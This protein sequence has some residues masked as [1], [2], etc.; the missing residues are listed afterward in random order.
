MWD[1]VAVL[2]ILGTMIAFVWMSVIDLKIRILPDELNLAVGVFGVLFHLAIGWAYISPV[3][4]LIGAIM[5]G[6]VL[7]LIRAVANRIY[8]MDTLG[9]G[10]VKLLT[11]VGIWLGPEQTMMALS[12][13][14]FAGLFHG[15]IYLAYSNIVHKKDLAFRGLT[16]P[17][18]PGFVV[19]AVAVGIWMY[20][21]LPLFGAGL[22][23]YY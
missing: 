19:G 20:K 10:D 9:L 23:E 16:I 6:G 3:E 14:A 15:I 8:G 17:A 7:L 22:G 13:G 12:V 2:A 18:G 4:T 5:G 1:I 21:D 11:A